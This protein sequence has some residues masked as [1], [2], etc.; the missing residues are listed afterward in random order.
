MTSSIVSHYRATDIPYDLPTSAEIQDSED[1]V[2]G[3]GNRKVVRV[4]RHFVVKYGKAIDI[5]EGEN[6]L[7]IQRNTTIAVPKVYTLYTEPYTGWN[8]IVME[9]IE[10]STLALAW[11]DL[12][13]VQKLVLTAKLMNFYNELRQLPSPGYF[14]SLGQ[15]PLLDDTFWTR[16]NVP[17]INGPFETEDALNEALAQKYTYDGRAYYKAEYYRQSLPHI[18]WGDQPTFAHGDCQRKYIMVRKVSL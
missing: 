12:N 13:A 3:Y 8:F 10:G 11:P 2:S 1:V 17:S 7:Y 9:Y 4:G 18:F 5:I 16:E 15:R 14:G 6:M